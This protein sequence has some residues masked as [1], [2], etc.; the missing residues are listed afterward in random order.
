MAPIEKLLKKPIPVVEG[1][2]YPMEVFEA[3]KRDKHGKIVNADDQE[4]RQAARERKKA[5]EEVKRTSP[6]SLPPH[7]GKV[8]PVSPSF[9]LGLVSGPQTT[10]RSSSL[11]S[12]LPYAAMLAFRGQEPGGGI[13]D[14][15]PGQGVLAVLPG[16]GRTSAAPTG[17]VGA[18]WRLP[19]RGPRRTP[20]SSAAS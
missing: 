6:Q 3:P 5:R 17:P 12:K 11:Q 10:L 19:T 20:L 2:P 13:H 15:L 16:P 1:H 7:G 14:L 4:A 18:R 9:R 8:A